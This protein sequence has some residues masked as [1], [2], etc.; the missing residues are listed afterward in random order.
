MIASTTHTRFVFPC[1]S[2]DTCRARKI[3]LEFHRLNKDQTSLKESPRIIQQSL[4][5]TV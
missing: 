3:R 1:L 4:D 5:R 2:E